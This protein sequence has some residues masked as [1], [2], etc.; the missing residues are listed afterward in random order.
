MSDVACMS[1]VSAHRAL[2]EPVW[3]RS[4]AC[5][6][7]SIALETRLGNG[8][9]R[10]GFEQWNCAFAQDARLRDPA[11]ETGRGV[12]GD[13]F[14]CTGDV[15]AAKLSVVADG[16]G[17]GTGARI[18]ARAAVDAVRKYANLSPKDLIIRM[19]ESMRHT[20][21]AAVGVVELNQERRTAIFS[22]VGNISARIFE[23]GASSR[24]MVSTNGTA[25]AEIRTVR[26][27]TYPWPAGA[28]VVLHSDGLSA[29][30]D[31]SD[32]PGLLTRDPGV[33]AGVLMRDHCRH[34]DD[35]TV[36][37]VK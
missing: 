19:H 9:P 10:T 26:E 32:Y 3:A 5:R 36:V 7:F 20:R 30:W 15:E 22:G 37:V 16:L 18:A 21:G 23:G 12:C 28:A 29:R 27:F 17:H 34:T 6:R 14:G 11:I 35:A 2:Q 25:G 33:I 8:D 31:L 4:A 24:Q 1:T 13:D